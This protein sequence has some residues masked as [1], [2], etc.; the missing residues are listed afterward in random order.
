MPKTLTLL[1]R[2]LRRDA[3]RAERRLWTGLRRKQIEGFRFRRQVALGPFIA[4]FACLE[5]R[6]IIEVD[7]ATHRTRQVLFSDPAIASFF[8]DKS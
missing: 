4:D 7:G 5:A 3:T 2:N 8:D 6:L 1:A